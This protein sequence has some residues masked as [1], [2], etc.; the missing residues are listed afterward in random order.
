MS[1]EC[2]TEFKVKLCTPYCM[3]QMYVK[4]KTDL[5]CNEQF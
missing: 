5:E 4:K 2:L 3:K 1:Q